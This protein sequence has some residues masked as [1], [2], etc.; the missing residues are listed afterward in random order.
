MFF[1]K[2]MLINVMAAMDLQD[3]DEPWAV[4]LLE[5]AKHEP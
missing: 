3:T 5:G 4:R 1:A 2:G